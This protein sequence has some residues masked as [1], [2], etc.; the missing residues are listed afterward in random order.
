MRQKYNIYTYST[1][2]GP[3]ENVFNDN[4]ELSSESIKCAI[5]I[6]IQSLLS[7]ET[8]ICTYMDNPR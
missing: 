2:E 1:Y 4:H 6:P 3:Y 7:R 5:E 8:N